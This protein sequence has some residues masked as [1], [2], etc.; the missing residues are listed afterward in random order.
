MG[1]TIWIGNLAGVSSD[2]TDELRTNLQT[3]FAGIASGNNSFDTVK[4]I[5][6]SDSISSK[7]LLCYIVSGF[8]NSV[9]KNFDSTVNGDGTAGNTSFRTGA[10]STAASEVYLDVITDT[11][12][13]LALGLSKLIFHELMHNK[14]TMGNELHTKGGGGLAAETILE[15]TARSQGNVNFMKARLANPVVQWQ[16]GFSKP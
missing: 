13:D 4:I 6:A 8:G 3:L 1:L 10:T 15:T 14:A 16:G 2:I 7:D 9:V 12:D 5:T 11:S